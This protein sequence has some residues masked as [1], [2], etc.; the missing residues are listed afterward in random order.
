MDH[1]PNDLKNLLETTMDGKMRLTEEHVITILY[2][3]LCA[4]NYI[5]GSNLI[6]RDLKPSNILIN[7]DCEVKI[8]D[9]GLARE[10]P[11]SIRAKDSSW[12]ICQ[13]MKE[14][15]LDQR[16]YDPEDKHF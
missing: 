15:Y 14:Q 8:C 1:F 10:V 5:H 16:M 6:H 9:F 13:K 3:I 12:T 4:V 2:N 7:A 11:K